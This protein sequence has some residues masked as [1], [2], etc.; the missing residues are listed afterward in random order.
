MFGRLLGWEPV[1]VAEIKSEPREISSSLP[2]A[3]LLLLLSWS[4][5]S[6]LSSIDW[7]RYAGRRSCI[8]DVIAL[9]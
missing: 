5:E 4:G 9:L 8:K 7:K 1:V 6:E 2:L 3:L